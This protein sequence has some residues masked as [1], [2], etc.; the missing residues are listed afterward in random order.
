VWEVPRLQ[1][2]I[3]TD[4]FLREW[5]GVPGIVIQ[6][7]EPGVNAE[8]EFAEEDLRARLMASWDEEY[9][10]LAAEWFDNTWDIQRVARRDAVWIDSSRKRR[11]RMAF[12]DYLK[13][14]IRESDYDYVLWFSPRV[15]GEGPYSW[16]RLLEG[17]KGMER[18]TSTPMISSREQDGRAT[19]EVLILWE[20]LRIKPKKNLA[21]PLNLLL[22]DSDS[23]SQT[24]ESKIQQLKSLHWRGKLRLVN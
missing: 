4:G 13:L 15:D 14:R 2:E 8:G 9:L 20:Q 23:P 10:Y 12:F 1:Q 11:D 18:A 6:S 7:G 22:A 5:K 17:Y 19:V 16:C 24:L 21:L 3:L